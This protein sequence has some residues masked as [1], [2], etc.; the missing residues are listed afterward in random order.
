MHKSLHMYT[1]TYLCLILQRAAPR[2]GFVFVFTYSH[3]LL[4]LSAAS[5]FIYSGVFFVLFF[6]NEQPGCVRNAGQPS[7]QHTC[8]IAG[9]WAHLSKAEK[10]KGNVL[11]SVKG[12]MS[13]S[14]RA[15]GG[16]GVINPL[17]V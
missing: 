7:R 16:D 1:F 5:D 6:L 13:F 14:G 15:D 17:K 10:F 8:T 4:L 9:A 3:L 12:H 2:S 11:H